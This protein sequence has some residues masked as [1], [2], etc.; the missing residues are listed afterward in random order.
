MFRRKSTF[1]VFTYSLII[2]KI[3]F[4][5]KKLT[6]LNQNDEQEENNEE[7]STLRISLL[8]KQLF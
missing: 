4:A 1:E 2:T 6:Y 5:V 7:K 3:L 8:F